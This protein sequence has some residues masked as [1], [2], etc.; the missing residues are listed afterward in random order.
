MQPSAYE[1][2]I[3]AVAGKSVDQLKEVRD[4]CSAILNSK[5]DDAEL[6]H[7]MMTVR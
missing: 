2:L 6:P 3:Q 4:N 7:L 1:S 5:S